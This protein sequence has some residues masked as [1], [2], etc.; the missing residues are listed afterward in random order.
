MGRNAE[1]ARRFGA[2]GRR[3]PVPDPPHRLV[4][5]PPLEPLAAG[6]R[7]HRIHGVRWRGGQ[8]NSSVHKSRF[9]PLADERGSRIPVLYAGATFDVAVYESLFPRRR[10]W[11][12]QPHL[13]RQPNRDRRALGSEDRARPAAR[14]LV[15]TESHCLEHH[16]PGT[17]PGACKAL[18]RDR[19]LG[20][21]RPPFDPRCGRIG[22][23]FQP[24]G[25]RPL[26][27]VLWRPGFR[28]RFRHRDAPG[29]H[30]TRRCWSTCAGPRGKV[31]SRSPSEPMCHAETK[32]T[33]VG[34]WD[35]R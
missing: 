18:R 33:T 23:D 1:P 17:H 28:A 12:G 11:T 29:G 10:S 8:F 14:A 19:S 27:R 13:A 32:R 2:P 7:L 24:R 4:P 20:R 30:T 5:V 6:S 15:P 31:T 21:G 9:A 22:L 26:L 16:R 34:Y 25:Q 3:V 35:N